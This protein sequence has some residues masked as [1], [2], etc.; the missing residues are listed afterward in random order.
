MPDT[1]A[2]D[3]FKR[4]LSAAIEMPAE[5]ATRHRPGH[6][7]HPFA[8]GDYAAGYYAYLRAEKFDA[9]G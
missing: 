5:I 7:Q 2:M 8:G 1:I 9:N 4:E 3:R 6:F